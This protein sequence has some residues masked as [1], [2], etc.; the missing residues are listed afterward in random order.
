MKALAPLVSALLVAASCGSS[1]P[2]GPGGT[3]GSFGQPNRSGCPSGPATSVRGLIGPD[4]SLRALCGSMTTTMAPLASVDVEGAGSTSWSV[5]LVGD[6]AFYLPAEHFVSCQ[7]NSPTLATARI[8]AGYASGPGA[9]FDAVATVSSDDGS[10]ATGQVNVHVETVA[11]QF[12]LAPTSV[13]FGDVLPDQ[14]VSAIVVATSEFTEAVAQPTTIL[15]MG[16]FHYTVD[17]GISPR[18]NGQVTFAWHDPGDYTDTWTW[19]ASPSPDGGAPDGCVTTK[20]VAL[21]A[22]VVAPDAGAGD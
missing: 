3:G 5:S 18:S 1:S 21:H 10:F 20:T 13:D 4:V 22:R 16:A 2:Q 12:T 7:S 6:R 17:A 11:P 15:T 9:T 14:Q 8:A 19:T